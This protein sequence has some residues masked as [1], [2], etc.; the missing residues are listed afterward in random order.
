MG[1]GGEKGGVVA[2]VSRS[3]VGPL[4]A[5]CKLLAGLYVKQSEFRSL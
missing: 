4:P 3:P 2:V 5:V 1:R